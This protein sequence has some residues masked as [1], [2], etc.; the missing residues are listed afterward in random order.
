VTQPTQATPPEAPV[1]PPGRY[2]HRRDPAAQRRRRVVG[3][4]LAAVTVLVGVGIAAK[5]YQQYA[6]SPYQVSL[7]TTTELSDSSFTVHFTVG[8]PA[9]QGARCT[10][11]GHTR[12]GHEVGR[13]DVDVPPK[14]PTDTSVD[15]TYTLATTARA[16]IGEVQGCGPR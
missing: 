11:V 3:I 4:V 15:V 1:F 12:D 8:T 6:A 9:G 16:V 2:G 7:V 14:G 13:A 10:V 5:L